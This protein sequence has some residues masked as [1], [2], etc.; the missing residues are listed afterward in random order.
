MQEGVWR[1][2]NPPTALVEMLIGTATME[3][4]MEVP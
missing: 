1:G 4:I 2:G 3:N